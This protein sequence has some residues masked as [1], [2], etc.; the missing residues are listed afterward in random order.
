MIWPE[1]SGKVLEVGPGF[2]KALQF[3]N[4]VTLNDG[5]FAVDPNTIHSYTALEPNPFL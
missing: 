1:I 3:L 2:A 5:T 4:H